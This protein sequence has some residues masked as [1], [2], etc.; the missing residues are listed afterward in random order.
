VCTPLTATNPELEFVNLYGAKE[1][2]HRNQFRQS[3]NPF[4]AGKEC[5]TASKLIKESKK[6]IYCK[7]VT[8]SM[9]VMVIMH[10]A[11]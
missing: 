5:P 10:Y 6:Q 2:I 11:A 7:K 9:Y 3:G 4:L 8:I 1:L